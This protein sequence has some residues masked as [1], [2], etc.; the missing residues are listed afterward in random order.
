[1]PLAFLIIG[2]LFIVA[3]V[4][5]KD[6]VDELFST[7]KSDFTGPGNFFYWGLSLF[8]I[9]AIGYYKPLKPVSTAFMTLVIL[10]LIIAHKGFIQQF[11][12]QLNGTTTVSSSDLNESVG[13]V[14]TDLKSIFDKVRSLGQ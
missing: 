13:Q 7:L 11:M 3:A 5:G 2:T 9:G 1:M 4:R 14:N 12:D 6:K 8:L 10:V